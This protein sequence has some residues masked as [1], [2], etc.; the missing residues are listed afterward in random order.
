LTLTLMLLG[1]LVLS[2][3]AS[4]PAEP[5]RMAFVACPVDP[6]LRRPVE[7]PPLPAEHSQSAMAVFSIAQE[8]ALSVA[9]TQRDYAVR[10]IDNCN[11]V[12]GKLQQALSSSQ[13]RAWWHVW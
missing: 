5:P 1:E 10:A 12:N 3:C 11:D 2:G 6:A 4:H 13:K 7:R 9:E 8:A